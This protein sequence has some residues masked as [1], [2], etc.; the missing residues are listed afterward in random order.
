[1]CEIF[2]LKENKECGEILGK[3]AI[4]KMKFSK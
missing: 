3:I 2:F 4:F 1:M